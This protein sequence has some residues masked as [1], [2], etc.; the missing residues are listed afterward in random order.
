MPTSILFIKLS[1]NVGIKLSSGTFLTFL[2]FV[3]PSKKSFREK[4]SI[5]KLIG[6]QSFQNTN[7]SLE[8]RWFLLEWRFYLLW[9][10]CMPHKLLGELDRYL[11]IYSFWSETIINKLFVVH[12][13]YGIN[14][15][16]TLMHEQLIG[17]IHSNSQF[18]VFL[19]KLLN[20][21]PQR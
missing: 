17:L 15:F 18:W 8:I 10:F 4:Y 7:K 9:S 1:K 16:K 14:I 5:L 11:D 13:V 12:G 19:F 21:P 20:V 3:I 2:H 6:M